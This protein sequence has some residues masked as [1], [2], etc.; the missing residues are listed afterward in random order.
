LV[1]EPSSIEVGLITIKFTALFSEM[2]EKLINAGKKLINAEI[3]QMNA[4]KMLVGGWQLAVSR[5]NIGIR[6]LGFCVNSG[7][8]SH[9]NNDYL[10]L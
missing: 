6:N 8:Q 3:Y 2:C 10:R 4:G 5:Q 9:L 1:F 7:L